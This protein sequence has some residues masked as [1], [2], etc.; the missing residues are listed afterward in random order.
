[1]ERRDRQESERRAVVGHVELGRR[2]SPSSDTDQLVFP[3]IAHGS[4]EFARCYYA[5]NDLDGVSVRS[6]SLND[7]L[8]DLMGNPLRIGAGGVHSDAGAALMPLVLTASQTWTIPGGF[9]AG[10]VSGDPTLSTPPSLDIA[11][12]EHSSVF[13][14][15]GVE[16]GPTTVSGAGTLILDSDLGRTATLNANDNQPVTFTGGAT[17]QVETSG[18]TGP[19]DMAGGTISLIDPGVGGGGSSPA[20]TTMPVGYSMALVTATGDISGTFAGI[21]DGSVIPTPC[22]GLPGTNAT[23]RINYHQHSVT[24]TAV[25]TGANEDE[26]HVSNITPE[27]VHKGHSVRLKT[28]LFDRT[29]DKPLSLQVKLLAR[30]KGGHHFK[31]IAEKTADADGVAKVS[32]KP[33]LTTAYEWKVLTLPALYAHS[34]IRTVRV[35]G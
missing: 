18:S 2:V 11:L 21:P 34:K 9:Q 33:K 23:V 26:V 22:H 14:T 35:I 16:V 20:C 24:A 31:L 19:L 25:T 5:V 17:L 12:A 6:L 8:Y 29:T 4:C 13:P 3:P 1:V 7:S 28:R 10:P 15:D 32:V 30:P 27:H